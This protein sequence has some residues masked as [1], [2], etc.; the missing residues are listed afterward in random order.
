MRKSE[1]EVCAQVRNSVPGRLRSPTGRG[2]RQLAARRN[3]RGWRCTSV[4][5][6]DLM[7][8]GRRDPVGAPGT[9]GLRFL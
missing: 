7:S 9:D 8:M 5:A 3:G 4:G 6:R 1:G 2:A